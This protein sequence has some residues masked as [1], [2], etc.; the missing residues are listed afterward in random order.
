MEMN[1]DLIQETK[2]LNEIIIGKILIISKRYKLKKSISEEHKIP[3]THILKFANKF[4]K[5]KKHSYAITIQ[6]INL[7]N[8]NKFQPYYL[9]KAN[10]DK[11]ITLKYL[12]DN[13]LNSGV[14][15][16]DH[17]FVK[18]DLFTKDPL[19]DILYKCY[20]GFVHKNADLITLIIKHEKDKENIIK[21]YEDYVK[22][23]NILTTKTPQIDWLHHYFI[24]YALSNQVFPQEL[25]HNF[26]NSIQNI[27]SVINSN[28]FDESCEKKSIKILLEEIN[29]NNYDSYAAGRILGDIM[30]KNGPFADYVS[31]YINS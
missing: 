7:I 31:N 1:V 11:F 3:K 17:H 26:C 6:L 10:L 29:K 20:N 28:R 9:P 21:I 22:N 4:I 23:T 15:N 5:R 25:V 30:T 14:L 18:N 27:K 8:K 13:N 12:Y 16:I 24:E 19:L 2:Y